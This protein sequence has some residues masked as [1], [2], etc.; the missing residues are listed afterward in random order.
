[1]TVELDI[2]KDK[3]MVILKTP[4]GQIVDRI[5]TDGIYVRDFHQYNSN[6]ADPEGTLPVPPMGTH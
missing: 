5:E 3:T 2:Y 6:H 1:M 4:D